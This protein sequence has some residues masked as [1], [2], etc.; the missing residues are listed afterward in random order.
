MRNANAETVLGVLRELTDTVTGEPVAVKAC[1]VSLGVGSL[2]QGAKV[3]EEVTFGP[4]V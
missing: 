3:R 2:L 1:A 4:P